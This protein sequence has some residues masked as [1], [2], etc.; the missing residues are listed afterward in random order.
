MIELKWDSLAA[1]SLAA[2]SSK[3]ACFSNPP[4]RVQEVGSEVQWLLFD[5]IRTHRIPL[6]FLF[7]LATSML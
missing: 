5:E 7:M 4:V 3:A 2:V 1:K 6:S